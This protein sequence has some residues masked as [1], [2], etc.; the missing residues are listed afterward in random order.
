MTK[1]LSKN[2]VELLKKSF[3]KLDTSAT[4]LLFY[5]KLFE[6]KPEVKPLFT[7]EI[8]EQSAKLMSVFELVVFSFEERKHNEF[9]LQEGVIAPL[10]DLGRK[11]DEKGILP[12]HYTLANKLLLESMTETAPDTMTKETKESWMI[13]LE[14]LSFA[15]LNDSTSSSAKTTKTSTFREIFS[16]IRKKIRG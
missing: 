2:Q 4:A 14:H 6:Q 9:V 13:A 5:K 8:N 12:E 3:R 7:T 10:R 15:M 1:P 16:T 11:H